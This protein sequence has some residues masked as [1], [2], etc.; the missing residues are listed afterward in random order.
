MNTQDV[1]RQ[2]EKQAAREPN[3]IA[4]ASCHGEL[5]YRELN[6]LSEKLAAPLRDAG[7]G[8]EVLAGICVPR[9]PA[10][11][12]AA[13]AIFKA[14][15]AYL[16]VD[17]SEPEARLNFMFGD[18]GVS[19]VVTEKSLKEKMSGANR[20][21]ITVDEMGRLEERRS[22]DRHDAGH[23]TTAA[24]GPKSLAYVIYTSGSTGT[25]KGVEVAHESLSNLVAWHQSAFK[26]IPFD[27]ASCVARV[28]FD[29]A[30]WEIWPYL[31]AGASLH[32]PDEEKLKDPEAFQS[33]LIAQGITISF[34]PTPMAERLL[35][36]K[37]PAN[38]A[39]R[40]MLTGGD[41]LHTYPS[42]ELPFLLV[43]NYGP[44]ECAVVAT[45]GLVST[46]RSENRLP[47]IGRPIA[48]TR[49]YL[50][51]ES[52]RQVAPG[53]PGEIY[54]GGLGVARG[55]RNRPELTA[56]RFIANPFEDNAS[57]L[58][59]TGDC[60]QTL[61]DGQIAFLGRF[62]EQIKIRG[63]R[64]EPNEIVAALN[65]HPAV[66]Q[67]VVVA[68]EI[69]QGDSRLV[70][71]FVPRAC[72]IATVSELRDFLGTRLPTYM[73]PAMFVT[74]QTIPL[75]PNGK[76]DRGALPEPDASN[77]LGEDVFHAPRTEVEHAVAGILAP[78]LGVERVDVEANFFA[79][80]G[81]S[82]LG[83]QLISRLRDALG[84]ELSLRTVFEAPSVA[85]LSAEIERLL[86]AKLEAMSEEE[87]QRTLGVTEKAQ[88]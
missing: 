9:S 25:P 63:F 42:T 24:L 21:V 33:W 66:S 34:V 35:A 56:E 79:L 13:L 17:P 3:A 55:Y 15:G 77:T 28:G 81:H 53:T 84:V 27:R 44:T 60:A 2:F 72:R 43:N 65:E 16:P 80:G 23:N 74:L 22:P 14:G 59:K 10:T 61:P 8:P 39:L 47:P 4:V 70:A 45:S 40:M 57:R 73:V 71:Y 29:A 68:R 6:D 31:T 38:S 78:L 67:S 75:T 12:V 19:V 37:W 76:V 54:I 86:C 50:L 64:I 69:T 48:N 58:F 11:M 46:Q 18:A 26:V 83:I 32:I 1:L 85:E 5:T 88:S 36:L 87:V 52:M 30:V 51:D 7:V 62:D 82:L 41:T 49:V 20:R